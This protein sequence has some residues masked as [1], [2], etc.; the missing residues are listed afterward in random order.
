M[1]TQSVSRMMTA[2]I[3]EVT[4]ATM[5]VLLLSPA[6]LEMNKYCTHVHAF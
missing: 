5:V 6:T 4:T 1:I 3:D 2:K